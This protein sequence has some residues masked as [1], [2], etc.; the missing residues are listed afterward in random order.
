MSSLIQTNSLD[1]AMWSGAALDKGTVWRCLEAHDR[2][3]LQIS[4]LD[5]FPVMPSRGIILRSPA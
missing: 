5:Y 3:F 2:I 1:A 4:E